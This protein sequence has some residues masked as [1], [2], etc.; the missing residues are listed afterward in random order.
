MVTTTASQTTAGNRRTTRWPMD[1][2][3]TATETAKQ[4]LEEAAK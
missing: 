2:T 4:Y 1:T 3:T